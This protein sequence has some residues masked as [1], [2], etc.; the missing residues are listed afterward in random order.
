LGDYKSAGGSEGFYFTIKR[1]DKS[2]GVRRAPTEELVQKEER[3]RGK[4]RRRK[5][6]PRC[7][8]SSLT[9]STS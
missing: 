3:G 6:M 4:G 8:E 7:S 2:G 9:D 5:P 1:P